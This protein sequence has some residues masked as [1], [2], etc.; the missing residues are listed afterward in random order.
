MHSIYL[1][2]AKNVIQACSGHSS[3]RWFKLEKRVTSGW[4]LLVNSAARHYV[5]LFYILS[6]NTSIGVHVTV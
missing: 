2:Y 3:G 6:E 5:M 1:N 4:F